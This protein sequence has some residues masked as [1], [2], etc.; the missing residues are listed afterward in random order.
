MKN[1]NRNIEFF[2]RR[3]EKQPASE[4]KIHRN[5]GRVYIAN[6]MFIVKKK[7]NR[8]VLTKRLKAKNRV[9]VLGT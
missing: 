1:V 5:N 4:L 8:D 6:D 3:R 7:K 9:R 2:S